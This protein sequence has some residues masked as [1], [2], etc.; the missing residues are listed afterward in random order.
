MI[1]PYIC[2]TE[3]QLQV[4]IQNPDENGTLTDGRTMTRTEYEYMECR[5]E[6]CGAWYD[7]RCQYK[8]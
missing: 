5:K 8:K 1:C 6:G 2:R 4:W 7:G 3:T